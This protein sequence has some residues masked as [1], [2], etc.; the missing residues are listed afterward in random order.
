MHPNDGFVRKLRSYDR[1]IQESRARES[2]HRSGSG[3]R[4][5]KGM[6]TPQKDDKR[7]VTT[8]HYSQSK[9]NQYEYRCYPPLG[10]NNAQRSDFTM[11]PNQ[12]QSC[13]G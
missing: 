12:K 1:E 4:S 8:E 7:T 9:A 10:S 2:M 6:Y 5:V 11:T 13:L 3:E